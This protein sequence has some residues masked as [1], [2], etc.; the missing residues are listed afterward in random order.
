MSHTMSR[1]STPHEVPIRREP[2]DTPAAWT[3]ATLPED[4]GIVALDARCLDEIG[5]AAAELDANP[6]PVEALRPEHFEMPRCRAVM[7]GV[8]GALEAGVGFAIVDRLPVDELGAAAAT[9]IYWLL[10]SMLGQPV[11]Q[12]WDG[13]LLYDV[14]D[15]GEPDG[16]GKG[17][18]SSKTR[19][20]QSY[21]TDNAFNLPPD[22]VALLCLNTARSGGLSGLLSFQSVYNCLLE[23]CPQVLER[24][25]EPF[26][27]DRQ[28][29]HA[30]GAPALSRGPLFDPAPAGAGVHVRLSRRLVRFGYTLAGEEMDARTRS[31]FDALSGIIERPALERAFGFERGQ[32]QVVNNRRLGHRRTA[33]EDWPDPARRRHMVR[34]WIRHA[35]RPFYMG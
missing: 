19:D 9:R 33:Y 16:P 23:E 35:G 13:T 10:M 17:V 5:A 28:H 32:F 7:A 26:W 29:E 3:A 15:A 27:F 18:R 11:A 25:Y 6:L 22:Y 14:T 12:K 24:L 20:G 4:A 2:I 8:R 31:A 30:P 21:H 34:I 1:P